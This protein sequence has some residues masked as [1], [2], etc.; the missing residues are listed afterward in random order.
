[1]TRRVILI[2]IALAFSFT[3]TIYFGYFTI[4][5]IYLFGISIFISYQFSKAYAYVSVLIN[6]IIFII[7]GLSIYYRTIWMP[8]QIPLEQF[9]LFTSNLLFLNIIMVVIIRQTLVNLDRSVLKESI[10]HKVLKKEIAATDQLNMKLLESEAHYKTL[11]F[12]SP[13]PKWIYDI[14]SMEIQQ[15]NM[16]AISAS[17]YTEEELLSM[18][19]VDLTQIDAD[20]TSSVST[21][22]KLTKKDGNHSFIELKWSDL[23]FNGRPSR[24]VIAA[25]ITERV[26]HLEEIEKQNEKLREISFMQAHIIRSPL[27]KIM[28]LSDLITKEYEQLQNEPL[29]MYLDK[30]AQELD[31]VIREIIRHSEQFP[32]KGTN[33]ADAI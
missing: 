21:V 18:S 14:E 19:V 30:S 9:T 12:L 2:T 27:T 3:S 32:D 13:L 4:G 25:D 33:S 7:T 26:N 5:A 31:G 28:A 1:M 29:F 20:D 16:A 8:V 6:F 22:K 11:F 23:L 17:G 24:L 15:V 10:L